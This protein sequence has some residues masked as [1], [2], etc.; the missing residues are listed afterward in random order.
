M[1]RNLRRIHNEAARLQAWDDWNYVA[2]KARAAGFGDLAELTKPAP[3]AGVVA[4][5]RCIASIRAEFG[6]PEVHLMRRLETAGTGRG[7][8]AP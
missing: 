4:I 2:D 6:W 5:D 1:G 7:E 8:H 3:G